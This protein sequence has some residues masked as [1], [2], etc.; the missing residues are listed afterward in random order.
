MKNLFGMIALFAV[1]SLV[2][3][4]VAAIA[5]VSSPT[6]TVASRVASFAWAAGMLALFVTD[7]TPRHSYAE[8]ITARATVAARESVP[9]AKAAASQRRMV[10][11]RTR[12]AADP[13]PAGA[14]A[15]LGLYHDPVTV[16]LL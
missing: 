8:S 16:S 3:L 15:T 12:P 7:Y 6:W 2:L 10:P 4:V 5:G 11:A 1:A 14:L 9:V 13:S